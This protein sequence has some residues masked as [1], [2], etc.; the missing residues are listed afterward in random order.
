MEVYYYSI[1]LNLITLTYLDDLKYLDNCIPLLYLCAKLILEP[2]L[3]VRTY[4]NI[5][6]HKK[7]HLPNSLLNLNITYHISYWEDR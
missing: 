2:H 7:V 5:I 1:I 6:T 4:S 3:T